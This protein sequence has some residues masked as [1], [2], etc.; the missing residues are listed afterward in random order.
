MRPP[1]DKAEIKRDIEE[2]GSRCFSLSPWLR[3][4]LCIR[5]GYAVVKKRCW[6]PVCL[7][8]RSWQIGSCSSYVHIGKCVNGFLPTV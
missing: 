7:A 4:V 6:T 2:A 8:P 3:D 5:Q 1:E